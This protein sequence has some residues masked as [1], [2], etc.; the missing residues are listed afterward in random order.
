[1]LQGL[2]C[3]C[4]TTPMMG[5]GYLAAATFDY[6]GSDC[7]TLG[8]R[9]DRLKA[10][11]AAHPKRAADQKYKTNLTNFTTEYNARCGGN[12]GTDLNSPVAGSGAVNPFTAVYQPGTSTSDQIVSS[13]LSAAAGGQQLTPSQQQALM[14]AQLAAQQANQP[15]YSQTWFKIVAVVGLVGLGAG[16]FTMVKRRRKHA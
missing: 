16:V 9:I 12:V 7:G 1:M 5:L 14:E 4:G 3:G 13:L 10:N 2:G 8:A 15:F 11:M 6:K